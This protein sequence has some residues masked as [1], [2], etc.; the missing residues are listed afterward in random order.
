MTKNS[1]LKSLSKIQVAI[2]S[3]TNLSRCDC[4][5]EAAII[6]NGDAVYYN[7][8]FSL[9]FQEAQETAA[10]LAVWLPRDPLLQIA[11][12]GTNH[13]L[14]IVRYRPWYEP[15]TIAK[16]TDGSR[17]TLPSCSLRSTS[18]FFWWSWVHDICIVFRIKSIGI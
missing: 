12:K 18:E 5:E 7:V 6:Y 3:V 11:L 8:L 4:E 16:R 2:S 1:E 13:E 14:F 9:G 15:S 10:L 17:T